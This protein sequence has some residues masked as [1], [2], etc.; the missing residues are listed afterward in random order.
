MKKIFSFLLIILAISSY[1]QSLDNYLYYQGVGTLASLAHPTNTFKSG[2]YK[3]NYSS[4]EVAIYYEDYTT[5]MTLKMSGN[6]FTDIDVR[7]DD[8]FVSPFV[9]IESFKDMIYDAIKDSGD[10]QTKNKVENY[11]GEKIEDMTGI[12][13]AC[14]IMTIDFFNY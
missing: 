1:T 6:M 4:V 2:E 11:F 5:K 14:L 7:Y 13:L 3:I 10:Q 9:A 12:Q 8:D